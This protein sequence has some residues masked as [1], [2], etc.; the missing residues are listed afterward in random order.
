MDAIKKKITIKG[1]LDCPYNKN[2]AGQSWCAFN[3]KYSTQGFKIKN[4][5]LD[6]NFFIDNRCELNNDNVMTVSSFLDDYIQESGYGMD[7]WSKEEDEI[8]S[9]FL[10]ILKQNKTI[11]DESN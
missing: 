2:I 8:M 10:K 7:M 1:C 3:Q 11:Q 6:N 9:R 5:F 4:D